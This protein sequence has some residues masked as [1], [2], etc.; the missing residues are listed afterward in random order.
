MP[1]TGCTA[2]TTID[3]SKGAYVAPPKKRP[4]TKPKGIV[5]GEPTIST[6]VISE[7]EEEE[8]TLEGVG[9]YSSTN[10][11]QCTHKGFE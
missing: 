6:P 8:P 5:I 10:R 9:C 2:S 3:K 1:T 11:G 7:A 4:P